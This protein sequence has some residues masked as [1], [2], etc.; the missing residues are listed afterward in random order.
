[1]MTDMA[2]TLL[3]KIYR[4]FDWLGTDV[5]NEGRR[6]Q[7]SHALVGAI[8][9][10]VITLRRRL[11][12]LLEQMQAGTL[13]P[14]RARVARLEGV[15][16]SRAER[17][18][19]ELPDFVARPAACLPRGFGWLRRLMPELQTSAVGTLHVML[20]EEQELAVLMAAAPQAGRTLRPL[21][22]ML[23]VRPPEYLRLARRKRVRRRKH[24]ALRRRRASPRPTPRRE[25]DVAER[26]RDVTGPAPR[27]WSAA[28]AKP[29][30]SEG[31][32]GR[33][34]QRRRE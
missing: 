6:R 12:S 34:Q 28:P 30:S 8:C 21:C 19:S 29:S 33:M 13:R 7:M 5:A 32:S 11:R 23:G 10:R 3:G 25:R 22:Q 20:H 17:A 24:A 2:A 15:R 16:E 26:E 31:Q 4:L 14:P 18:P 1:M 27:L 9:Y